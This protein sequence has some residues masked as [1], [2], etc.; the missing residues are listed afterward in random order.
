[1]KECAWATNKL[2]EIN[3]DPILEMRSNND[4]TINAN[5]SAAASKGL[6]TEIMMLNGN[7]VDRYSGDKIVNDHR[8]RS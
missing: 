7:K 2:A 1:M 5:K 3:P 8:P 6:Q 4:S